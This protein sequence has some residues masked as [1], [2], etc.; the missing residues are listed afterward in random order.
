VFLQL[1]PPQDEQPP[2]GSLAAPEGSEGN[3]T[4]ELAALARGALAGDRPK[5]AALLRAVAPT[6]LRAVRAVMGPHDAD[7]SDAL[8]ES[9]IALGPAL[10]GFESRSS[11]LSFARGVAVRTALSARR[12]ARRRR[13]HTT[14]AASV[15]G[16]LGHSGDLGATD[17]EAVGAARRR[18][19]FREILDELPPEQ[20]E[21]LALRVVMGRSLGEV[22]AVSGAPINTIRSRI[23]LA[24]EHLRRRIAADR[25][26]ADLLLDVD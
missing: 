19:A 21:A 25:A 15:L 4:D 23:R 14:E 17:A 11:V 18:D 16:P 24:K 26:L 2:A 7:A 20:A 9:L 22:A 12:Q 6:M 8:Q 1:V 13:H 5:L 10:K 3:E